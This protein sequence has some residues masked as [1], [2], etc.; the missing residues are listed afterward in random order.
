VPETIAGQQRALGIKHAFGVER[1]KQPNGNI[2][3]CVSY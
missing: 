2:S 3:A 1:L